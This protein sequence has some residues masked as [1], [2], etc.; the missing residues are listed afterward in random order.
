MNNAEYMKRALALWR[1]HDPQGWT[2][3]AVF[4]LQTEVGEITDFYK[5][6]WYTPERANFSNDHLLYELGDVLY[7]LT[8]IAQQEGLTLDEIMEANITKLEERYGTPQE[9]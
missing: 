5:K 1:T 7:Y 9:V 4:G 3:H 8:M 6:G 2:T